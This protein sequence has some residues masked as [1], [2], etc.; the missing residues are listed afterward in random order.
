[1]TRNRRAQGARSLSY[2][3]VATDGT[4]ENCD[5]YDSFDGS[6]GHTRNR[7]EIGLAGYFSL[8]RAP[9]VNSC[10]PLL[11]PERPLSAFCAISRHSRAVHLVRVVP[12]YQNGC[13]LPR[14]RAYTARDFP[15][16]RIWRS[17]L[18][19][20]LAPLRH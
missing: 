6:M 13:A 2:V 11:Y 7:S 20:V 17:R 10:A 18:R 5:G 12:A 9:L 4:V 15:C 1:M 8:L 3:T 14:R 19:F 16:A